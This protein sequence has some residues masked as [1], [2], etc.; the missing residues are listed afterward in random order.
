MFGEEHIR[1]EEE[2]ESYDLNAFDSY[3]IILDYVYVTV[4]RST[5]TIKY[6]WLNLSFQNH[7]VWF[8]FL[9]KFY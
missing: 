5:I 3:L 9:A 8:F 1:K 4:L 7:C 6:K 2:R